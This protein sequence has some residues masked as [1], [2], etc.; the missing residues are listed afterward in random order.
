MLGAELVESWVND[1]DFIYWC[2]TVCLPLLSGLTPPLNCLPPIP[3][4]EPRK[5]PQSLRDLSMLLGIKEQWEVWQGAH[6][7]LCS[8]T[9]KMSV[10]QLS[11]ENLL[12]GTK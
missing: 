12:K 11:E 3:H 5:E 6:T 10:I 1:R 7:A 9:L 2:H 8:P 4:G